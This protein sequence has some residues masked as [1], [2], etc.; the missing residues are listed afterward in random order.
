M[1][2]LDDADLYQV[3]WKGRKSL[4]QKVAAAV[5]GSAAA[6]IRSAARAYQ[7]TRFGGG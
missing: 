6:G 5:E 3:Q 4:S 7:E 2:R 1:A